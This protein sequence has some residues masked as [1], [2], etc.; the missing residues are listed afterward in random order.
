MRPD[1][2]YRHIVIEGRTRH[3]VR[4]PAKPAA[5]APVS[6]AAWA[7]ARADDR[8]VKFRL[9]DPAGP[10]AG[11]RLLTDIPIASG[12]FVRRGDA[13]ELVIA[14]PQVQRMEYLLDFRFADG[15][16]HTGTDPGNPLQVDG[17]FGAKSVVEFPSYAAPRW[18]VA[19]VAAPPGSSRDLTVPAEAL[20]D[21]INLRL[22]SPAG[23]ADDEPL[24]LLLAHDGPEYDKLASL[25]GYLSAG[26]AGGWLPRLRAAL[27]GPGQR[28]KWYS[29]NPAYSRALR[30][31]VLP[32]IAK[33]APA[34]TK[35]GMGTSLGAL[36]MLHAYCRDPGSLDAMFL[37]SGS[38]F[39]PRL[40]EQERRFP[41][42]RRITRFVTSVH[43]RGLPPSLVP[44]VLTCG[45]IEENINNNRL[46]TRTLQARGY[47]AILHEL[48]DMHNYTAWR[49]A[50]DPHL[51]G[52][53][54][55]VCCQPDQAGPAGPAGQADGQVRR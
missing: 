41:Y 48:P 19:A 18:L 53:L 32:A 26:V 44:V 39:S 2:D 17:A 22:W 46:M 55:Q 29:A 37:Q 11:L 45:V 36:A 5:E 15:S 31:A 9:P 4:V 8:T 35:I 42:Y 24:P 30:E 50:F 10:L 25:T 1:P 16:Q 27:L 23:T 43:A 6:P 21:V 54:R 40:D 13:W 20:G 51:T 7:G 49:D 28:D 33:A 3:D 52:L 34:T 47:P 12:E 14:R 38:F